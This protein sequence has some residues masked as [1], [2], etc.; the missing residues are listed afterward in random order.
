MA[1]ERWAEVERLYH[2]ALARAPEARV[3]FLREACAGDPV[4]RNAVEALLAQP[5]SGAVLDGPAAALASELVGSSSVSVLTGRQVG[6]YQILERLGVGGMGEVYRARD[7]RLGR[8]VAIKILPRDVRDD[9]DRLARF[10][11]EARALAALNHP[12][13]GAIYGVEEIDGIPALVLELID[14]PTLADRIARGRLPVAEAL[15]IARQVADALDA[16]HEKGIVHRDLKPANIKVRRDGTVK[17]LDF[18]LAKLQPRGSDVDAAEAR[19][20]TVAGTQ[21]G[22]IVGTVAYMS[23]EQARG[24][25]VD[26]RTDIWAF[27]CVLYE[28]LTGHRAFEAGTLSDTLAA[29]LDREPNWHGLPEKT[30][31]GLR[32][33]LL[34]CLEKDPR[35]RLHHIADARIEV[36]DATAVPPSTPRL[37]QW[38][39]MAT[40]WALWSGTVAAGLVLAATFLPVARSPE[41]VL[42]PVRVSRLTNLAGLE[43]WP[44]IS[45]DGR[46][47]AFTGRVGNTRQV[48]VQLLA[49]GAPL[50]L[51]RD[52]ADHQFPRWS[53]DLSSI[54]YFST[55]RPGETEGAI[56]EVPALGGQPRRVANSLGGADVRTDGRLTFFRLARERIQL[57]TGPLDGS[58]SQVV[59]EFQPVTYYLYPRWSPD[60]RWIAFQRGDSIRFDLFVVA[61][62][63]GEP[64]QLTRDNNTINGFAWLPDSSGIVYSSSRGSTMPY[65]PTTNLWQVQLAGGTMRQIT[66]GEASYVHPDI[67]RNGATVVGRMR[68]QTDVWKFPVEGLPPD[69]VR[70]AI[71]VT[72]QTGQILTPTASPDDKEV[73][74]LSDSGG[75]A[76]LWIVNT[77]TG[78][79]RQI[80]HERDPDVAVGVPVW[81]PDGRSIAFVYS[82]GNPGFTFGVWLVGPDGSNLRQVANPGLGPAWSADGQ[83]VYYSTRGSATVP[84]AVMMKIPADGGTAVTVTR[85]G[86]RNVIGSDGSTLYYTFERPLVDGQPEFEIRAANPESAPSRV[87]ARVP[88]SRV[89]IWQ[90]VSPALSPDGQ[91]L[92]QA[93]TD[94]STTN[95]WALSTS[96]GQWRQVTDFGQRTTFIARRVS[97]SSDSRAILA[98]VGEGDADIVLLEGLMY[99]SRP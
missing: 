8:D 42:Q 86:L 57:V 44:A 62:A 41:L 83:W 69:N 89:P 20:M 40:R 63:G 29:V 96:M 23:P 30:P 93:L 46:S 53:P 60:G 43:E 32:R 6:V 97:W 87:L 38:P 61:A 16:A 88:S 4:L 21:A 74:F 54:V 82:R 17:V 1:P 65:L 35:R 78:E 95:I 26:K 18:G 48:F 31:D 90:I 34:R 76:N 13:I 36:E 71:R 64:R 85:E 50:Q 70:R 58:G 49:G 81:S 19:T 28:M 56:W 25:A 47:V 7:P 79:L 51:T 67:A 80:T 68:L 15:G 45:P 39:R 52:P 72:N 92:A 94:G 77:E 73:A 55:A 91:W 24:Q 99:G 2:E 11:R 12:H 37:R 75:R 9:P 33:L 66:T 14:G 84:D 27:G 5:T 98:A 22:L 3:T 10:E 59:A